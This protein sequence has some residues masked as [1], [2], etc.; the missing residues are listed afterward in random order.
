[1]VQGKYKTVKL[2]ANMQKKRK[3][4]NNE[5]FTRRANAPIQAKKTKLSENQKIKQVISK[6][7]NKMVENELRARSAHS[8][9]N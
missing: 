5:A 8:T 4:S 7:V 1:M 3:R 2:S 9:A 6:S